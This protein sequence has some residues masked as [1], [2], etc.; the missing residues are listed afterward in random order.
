MEVLGTKKVDRETPHSL[1]IDKLHKLFTHSSS[2][3]VTCTKDSFV[4]NNVKSIAAPCWTGDSE[5]GKNA[6][7]K[8]AEMKEYKVK[9][10]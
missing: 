8:R 7:V 1:H 3:T 10:R 4:Y 9:K 6:C 2:L 5:K